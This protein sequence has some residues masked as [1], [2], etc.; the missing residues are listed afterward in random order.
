MKSSP[1]ALTRIVCAALVLV[2][3]GGAT[4]AAHDSEPA[5][6]D[7][8]SVWLLCHQ[9]ATRM[10]HQFRLP[11]QLLSAIAL[12]ESGRWDRD[13]GE[14]Y[15]WPWTVVAQGRAHYL[16]TRQ[17]AIELIHKLRARGVRNIDVGCMQ[18][19]LRYH[20]AAFRSVDEAIDPKTNVAY[21]A[22]FL[23]RLHMRT[24]S[25]SESVGLYHSANSE[26]GDP[27]RNKVFR[28]WVEERKRAALDLRMAQI[29]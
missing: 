3:A 28:I 6:H 10:E 13:R 29:Q 15:A 20:G 24:Q 21:A 5:A 26:R 4:A 7:E 12:A 17:R 8:R 25:W 22:T 14:T 9:T 23:R 18:V 11:P 2:S 19:N 27:Y 1:G 16:P